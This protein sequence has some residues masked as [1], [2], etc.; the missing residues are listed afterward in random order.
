MLLGAVAEL[1]TL[2]AILPLLTVISMPDASP[3]LGVVRPFLRFLG[4]QTPNQETIALVGGFALAVI[5]ATAIRLRLLWASQRFIYGL[6]YEIGVKLYADSLAQTYSYHTRTNTSEIISSISKS[7]MLISGSLAPLL[8]ALVAIVMA[9]FIVGGLIAINPLIAL[10][11]GGGFIFVYIIATFFT[12]SPLR[13]NGVIVARAQQD[14][15]RAMQE[16]LGGIR[17]VL[18]DRSQPVFVDTYRRAEA[19]YRDARTR[20]ALLANSPRFV[21]EGASMVLIVVMAV[22]LISGSGGLVPAVPTLGALALGAQ[23]LLPL[24]QQIFSGWAAAMSGRQ[25]LFDIVSLLDRPKHDV[26]EPLERIEFSKSIVLDNISYSYSDDHGPALSG[27]S[28][29]IPRGARIGL[30]GKTG[31]GKSTLT[32][33]ILGLLEPTQGEMRIDNVPVTGANRIAWQRNIT[34]VPQSIFLTDASI[35]ENIAFGVKLHEI[36]M[37]RVR[38]AAERAELA[39]FVAQLRDGLHTRVGE[40]GVQLSGGQ[41]Q[42]IGIARALYKQASVLVFDE[43]TS[44]LDHET[45]AAV[46]KAIERLDRDLTVIM[47]AHRLTT[48]EGCD[49]VLRLEGGRV[50]ARDV[51]AT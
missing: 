14:K 34:H 27:V 19:E 46:I 13:R 15:V 33:V 30:V 20:N 49:M 44:A 25:M 12:K 5:V 22:V 32:D 7:E 47:I 21:V 10:S 41:R 45:E 29:E 50:V 37:D 43:A 18:I 36:D 48:L 1:F 16:G 3:V 31:S 4:A 40:R 24:I 17:D 28:I 6:A 23:R 2:G 9:T 51:R 38:L 39:E 8:S 26:I 35:A 11:A 42:R